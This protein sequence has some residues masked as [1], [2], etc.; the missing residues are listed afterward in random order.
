MVYSFFLGRLGFFRPSI[1]NDNE[2]L[3]II[4]YVRSY[5]SYCNFVEERYFEEVV[6]RAERADG[7]AEVD[8]SASLVVVDVGVPAEFVE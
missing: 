6:M 4:L 3:R 7:V 8:D 5:F 1:I 2:E